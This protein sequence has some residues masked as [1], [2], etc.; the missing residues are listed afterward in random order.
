MAA[1]WPW[2]TSWRAS[3]ITCFCAPPRVSSLIVNSTRMRDLLAP[4][5][6]VP[7]APPHLEG[8]EEPHFVHVQP[9]VAG[10]A[11][12]EVRDG[13]PDLVRVEQAAGTHARGRQVFVDERRQ[14]APQ[15][16]RQRDCEALLGTLDQLARH[17][18]V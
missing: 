8:E 13:A 4:V 16:G 15:P 2:R 3:S 10:P 14:L 9:V 6:F 12:A 11:L 18:A 5:T 17:V 7:T 1:S